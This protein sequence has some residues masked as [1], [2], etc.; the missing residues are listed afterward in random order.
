MSILTFAMLRRANIERL[1]TFR[2]AKGEQAHSEPDGSDWSLADWFTAVTGEVG[3]LG[4]VLKKVRRGDYTLDEMREDIG[5][6]LADVQIYLDILAMRCGVDLGSAT[7]SKFNE[8]SRRVQSP[9][10]LKEE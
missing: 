7:I 1:P 5:K 3:E 9:V 2:N 8:V 10:F 6:E 4:N